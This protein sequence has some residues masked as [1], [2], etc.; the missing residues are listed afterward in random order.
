MSLLSD[1]FVASASELDQNTLRHGPASRFPTVQMRGIDL[2]LVATLGSIITG[3]K[4]DEM[5]PQL[6]PVLDLGENGPWIIQIPEHMQIA[7]K[8][9]GLDRFQD[10]SQQWTSNDEWNAQTNAFKNAQ[11]VLE[12]LHDMA[13][14][15]TQEHKHLYMWLCL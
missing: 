14:Q 5:L 12:H 13:S 7:L 15:A 9:L 6:D 11:A 2:V 8:N 3:V 1:F 10:I 4:D